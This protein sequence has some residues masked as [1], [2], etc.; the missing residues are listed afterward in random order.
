MFICSAKVKETN[1]KTF[2]LYCLDCV[3]D[4]EITQGTYKPIKL[5]YHPREPFYVVKQVILGFRAQISDTH[6]VNSHFGSTNLV[7]VFGS[8]K[9]WR[10]FSRFGLKRIQMWLSRRRSFR[11][12]LRQFLFLFISLFS[13]VLNSSDR[14]SWTSEVQDDVLRHR[15][16]TGRLFHRRS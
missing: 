5:V 14:S 4:Q 11:F 15:L 13:R 10:R 16:A 1:K 8:R 3:N 7:Y 9:S 6:C 12:A 2:Y